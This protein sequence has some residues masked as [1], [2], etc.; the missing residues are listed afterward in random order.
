[1]IPETFLFPSSAAVAACVKGERD[2][3]PG[4]GMDKE[5]AKR[6]MEK[7]I[8]FLDR[9][10]AADAVSCFG[11]VLEKYGRNAAVLSWLG[12]A[13]ARSGRGDLRP[14]ERFCREAVER[15]YFNANFYRNLAEVYM[16]W[17]RKRQA[18]MTL[19]KGLSVDGESEA[20]IRELRALGIRRRP[21]IPFLPRSSPLNKY[22]GIMRS[23]LAS[24]HL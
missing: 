11:E 8:D 15:E 19:R 4:T 20:L 7:G 21:A 23:R 10:W 24:R 14:A 17:G 2:L 6:L 3:T 1:M 16:I 5:N 22:I 12:L 13:I 9:G 18:I